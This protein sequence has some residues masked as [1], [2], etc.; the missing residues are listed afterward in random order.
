VAGLH[1][2]T[3]ARVIRHLTSSGDETVRLR[4]E[5][6]L[7]GERHHTSESDPAIPFLSLQTDADHR[8]TGQESAA[9]YDLALSDLESWMEQ[10]L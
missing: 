5:G 8:M 4:T 10:H 7:A 6:T 3:P 2:S 1:H 9:D